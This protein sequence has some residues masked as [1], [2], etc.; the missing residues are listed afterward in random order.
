LDAFLCLRMAE[1]DIFLL[2]ANLKYSHGVEF[3]Q[4]TWD[5]SRASNGLVIDNDCKTVLKNTA[6]TG[7][8]LPVLG[9]VG[10]SGGLHCWNIKIVDAG[11]INN[12]MIGV[13]SGSNVSISNYPG[14]G[15][16]KG[17]SYYGAN[18]H[19]YFRNTR[20]PFGPTF[21]SGDIIGTLLNMKHKTVTFY[22]NGACIGTAISVDSLTDGV[23]Y[24]CISLQTL[25]QEI[26]SCEIPQE[27]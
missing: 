27:A 18:G 6:A 1:T 22:K 9:T 10:F 17:V 21:T 12:I 8:F 14:Y 7:S 4:V 11:N 24:P 3:Y 19:R 20:E 23:Y 5:C 15:S 16:D 2:M 25:G 26:V 13:S